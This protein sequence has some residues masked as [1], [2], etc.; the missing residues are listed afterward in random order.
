MAA[1]TSG[2]QPVLSVGRK[3]NWSG[4]QHHPDVENG[5]QSF[6]KSSAQTR[7]AQHD[8]AESDRT[9]SFVLKVSDPH[10]ALMVRN[11]EGKERAMT[12]KERR[13]LY[14]NKCYKVIVKN[15]RELHFDSDYDRKGIPETCVI[16]TKD[17]RHQS[18]IVHPH[19]R[20]GS[21]EQN[22]NISESCFAHLECLLKHTFRQRLSMNVPSC[23]FCRGYVSE[24]TL[25]PIIIIKDD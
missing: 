18:I 21:D 17:I 7:L 14:T 13:T 15:K 4:H 19:F 1:I 12:I 3:Q 16:C 23:P 5:K 2:Y 10:V 8:Q 22:D 24:E 20:I 9:R 6:Q 25:V 11:A